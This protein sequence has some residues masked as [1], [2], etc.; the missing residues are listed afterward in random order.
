[1]RQPRPGPVRRDD[2]WNGDCAARGRRD[3]HTDGNADH[4]ADRDLDGHRC[5]AQPHANIHS[6][7]DVDADSHRDP[8]S[9]SEHPD[10]HRDTYC[11]PDVGSYP[12]RLS[13]VFAS[14]TDLPIDT[15]L[16]GRIKLT[17]VAGT[18]LPRRR[19]L[20]K[21]FRIETNLEPPVAA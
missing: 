1:M 4:H 11:D 15:P 21:M 19:P 16:A 12:A 9:G 2:A 20:A 14:L 13:P 5:P 7:R 8:D 3:E 18:A 6:R 17:E 10:T